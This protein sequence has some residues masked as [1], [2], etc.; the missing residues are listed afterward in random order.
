MYMW[1]FLKIPRPLQTKD[2]N[3]PIQVKITPHTQDKDTA[4]QTNYLVHIRQRHCKP[5]KLP[6]TQKTKI[7]ET[8]QIAWY[9][10]DMLPDVK[11]PTMPPWFVKVM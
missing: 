4:N 7:L 2:K 3:Y 11:I 1:L 9:T 8:G 6:G 10:Q 5:D